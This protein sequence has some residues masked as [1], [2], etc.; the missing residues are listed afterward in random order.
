MAQRHQFIAGAAGLI[1]GSLAPRLALA[2]VIRINALR[3]EQSYK[4][5]SCL[6]FGV[7]ALILP[8]LMIFI[9]PALIL[10]KDTTTMMARSSSLALALCL[11]AAHPAAAQE[12][13]QAFSSAQ[14]VSQTVPF[15]TMSW[16]KSL[17]VTFNSNPYSTTIVPFGGTETRAL[18]FM[19]GSL[20]AGIGD[21]EDP[22]FNNP[23]T[24]GPQVLRLDYPSGSWVEDQN[25]KQLVINQ[26]GRKKYQAISIL[27]TVYFDHDMNKNPITPVNVLLA[28]FWNNLSPTMDIAQKTGASGGWQVVSL[29]DAPSGQVRSFIGY[30]DSVTGQEMAFAGA[31]AI[32][33]GAYDAASHN[34]LWDKHPEAGTVGVTL[35][36][37]H[38]RVMNMVE[39]DGSLYATD[40]TTV[41]R[42]IDGNTPYWKI[43]YEVAPT[44]AYQATAGSGFR[45]LS[46]VPN[47][48]GAGNMLIAFWEGNGGAAPPQSEV[49][50]YDIP[51]NKDFF[52]AVV[53]KDLSLTFAGSDNSG[54]IVAYNN[55]IVYPYSGSTGCPDII[56][57]TQLWSTQTKTT[58]NYLVR[59]CD[60]SYNIYAIPDSNPLRAIRSIVVSQ[61]PGDP[62]GTLYAGGYDADDRPAHNTNWV[63][64]GLPPALFSSIAHIANRNP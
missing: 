29:A 52:T 20:Y 38:E 25:L 1:A 21:W 46:C 61:F 55:T 19:D 47:T 12:A 3:V 41:L 35:G 39:C 32:F 51:T 54:G 26:A 63:S 48:H 49:R 23:S 58:L 6:L 44:P 24:P 43:I 64:R 31:Y 2:N 59:H 30:T 9:S 17:P 15:P 7:L 45:G 14:A 8:A 56:A 40:Y 36:K 11:L 42:R 13:V 53:E 33:S 37:G 60:G 5:V 27:G 22:L 28:G 50:A 62:V 10:A 18:V 16:E 4:S 57:G 34:V